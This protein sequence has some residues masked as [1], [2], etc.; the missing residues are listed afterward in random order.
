MKRK[1]KRKARKRKAKKAKRSKARKR[2]RKESTPRRKKH[3]KMRRVVSIPSQGK[4]AR[5]K[6][7]EPLFRSASLRIL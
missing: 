1:A 6:N 4:K 5:A 7:N 3:P 2:K